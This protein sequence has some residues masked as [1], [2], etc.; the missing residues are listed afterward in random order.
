[1]NCNNVHGNSRTLAVVLSLDAKDHINLRITSFPSDI[2]TGHILKLY[3]H[4]QFA[5]KE[6]IK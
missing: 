2:R 3:R 6:I 5:H 4:S 1:M